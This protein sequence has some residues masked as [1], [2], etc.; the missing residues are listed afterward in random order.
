MQ[1]LSLRFS[2]LKIVALT[3][4]GTRN[5]SSF[6][7]LFFFSPVR[8]FDSSEG[9][10][11]FPFRILRSL[12]EGICFFCFLSFYFILNKYY[13]FKF[14]KM[15]I[16]LLQNENKNENQP[17][18]SKLKMNKNEMQIYQW[19]LFLHGI[20]FLYDF[21]EFYSR[22]KD[23][24][25]CPIIIIYSNFRFKFGRWCLIFDVFFL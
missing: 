25:L 22:S 11:W 9:I 10:S 24:G 8:S 13:C 14:F 1:T 2:N 19:V 12:S 18:K 5:F 7:S 3:T 23:R 21:S 4:K 16:Q 15:F 6:Y 20:F 17:K